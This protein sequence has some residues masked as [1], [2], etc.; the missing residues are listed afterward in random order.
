MF[1]NTNGTWRHNFQEKPPNKGMD[2]KDRIMYVQT[3][4]YNGVRT[5]VSFLD[6]LVVTDRQTPDFNV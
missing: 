3:A 2:F 1:L 4:G 6:I 5:V